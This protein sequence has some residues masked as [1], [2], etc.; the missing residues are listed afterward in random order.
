MPRNAQR[1]WSCSFMSDSLWP[2]GLSPTSLFH[3]CNFPGKTTGVGCHF[4]LQGIVPIQ[5]LNPGLLH[6]RQV[7]YHLSHQ[8]SLKNAQ[9]TTQLHSC[10]TLVKSC[11]KFSKPGF[12]NMWTVNFQMFKLDL[13]KTEEPEIKLPTSIRSSKKQESSRKTSTSVLLTIS[14]PLTVWI[15]KNCGKFLKDG[16]TRPPY[17]FPEKPLC[18]SR[19]NS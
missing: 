7:L 14:K 2:H 18:R 8:G 11:S 3:P 13:E 5:G 19:S 17:L 10:H 9:T 4:L 12:S 1:K 6:C 16:N 15:K